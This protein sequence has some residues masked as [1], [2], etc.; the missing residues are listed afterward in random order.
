MVRRLRRLSLRWS[1]FVT[2]ERRYATVRRLRRLSLRCSGWCDDTTAEEA[3]VVAVRRLEALGRGD[4]AK[5][6]LFNGL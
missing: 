5:G 2:L 1:G 6:V 4:E 3:V